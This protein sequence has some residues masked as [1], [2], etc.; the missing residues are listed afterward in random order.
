MGCNNFRSYR[1]PPFL[2]HED[3]FL[4]SAEQAVALL[5]VFPQLPGQLTFALQLVAQAA[6]HD[7]CTSILSL[8]RH[9]DAHILLSFTET[10]AFSVHILII[11]SVC[12]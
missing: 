10:T 9:L 8:G 6:T 7:G 12:Q 4:K 2:I 5:P 1:V 3:A 11:P